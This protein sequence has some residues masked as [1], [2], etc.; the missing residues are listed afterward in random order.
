[1]LSVP[2]CTTVWSVVGDVTLM[3]GTETTETGGVGIGGEDGFQLQLPTPSPFD[4]STVPRGV[5]EVAIVWSV[6][7]A[8]AAAAATAAG[9]AEL[10]TKFWP[11]EPPK[12]ANP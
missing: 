6:V 7:A 2:P 12:D 10:N 9:D 4:L 11:T 8:T 5:G 3:V 1:M